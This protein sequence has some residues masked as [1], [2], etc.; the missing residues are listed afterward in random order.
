MTAYANKSFTV[1]MGLSKEGR[2]NWDRIFGKKPEE[3]SKVEQYRALKAALDA[4]R[5]EDA[6]DVEAR[7]DIILEAMQGLY[8]E[9]SCEEQE[10]IVGK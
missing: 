1:A 9:M 4:V 3:P 10:Q 5:Q 8:K 6:R 7:E 2:D